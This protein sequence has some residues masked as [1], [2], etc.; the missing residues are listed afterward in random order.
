MAL[1]RLWHETPN[2]SG[3]GGSGVRLIV[4]HTTEG[5]QTNQSLWNF[6]SQPSA[7][8][9]YHISVDNSSGPNTCFEYV[10]RENKAWSCV[11]FNPRSV[12][13]A[14]CT[15]SGAASNWSRSKWLEY[16]AGLTAMATWVRE[17]AAAFGIPLVALNDAQAQSNGRGVCQ[18]ANLGTGGGGHHDCGPGFPMDELIRRAKN[19]PTPQPPTPDPIK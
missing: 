4:V 14:F 11:D 8:A 1:Q 10:K 3:R 15:P 6:I 2:Q 12:N 7:Q 5:S 18:H 19:E 16:D 13:G 17:E 9:S